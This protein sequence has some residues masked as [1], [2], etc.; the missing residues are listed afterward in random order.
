MSEHTRVFALH[1]SPHL[2]ISLNLRVPEECHCGSPEHGPVLDVRLVS[3]VIRVLYGCGHPLHREESGQVGRVGGDENQ[4]EE[5]PD[6]A[7]YPRRGGTGVEV[8]PLLHQRAHGEP[9]AVGEG[10]IVLDS[11]ARVHTGVGG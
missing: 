3:Q 1:E 5:P 4:G 10:E 8:R 2:L 6:A 9:E 7:H 11:V